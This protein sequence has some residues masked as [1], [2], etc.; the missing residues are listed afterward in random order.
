MR[1][2]RIFIVRWA[3]CDPNGH[4]RNTS[5]S[6]Y[7]IDTRMAYFAENGFPWARFEELGFGPVILRE[8][9]EYLLEL[10][11]GDTVE[12]DFA[13]L[14]LSPE[15][16][17]WKVR[18]EFWRPGGKVAGRVVVSGGWLDLRTRKLIDAPEPLRKAL[19]A[20]PRAEGFAELPP[21]RRG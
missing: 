14:G 3:D 12:V 19:E 16:G 1:Y 18:H 9:I 6:E 8:E 17:R 5:Y 11:L 4:M 2:T 7:A 10:K 20:V 13:Q 15:G 21:L